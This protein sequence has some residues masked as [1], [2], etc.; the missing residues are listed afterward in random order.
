MTWGNADAVVEMTRKIGERE[1]GLA[2]WLGEG[3]SAPPSTT[4]RAPRPGRSR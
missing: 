3:T 2:F 4:A 1:P